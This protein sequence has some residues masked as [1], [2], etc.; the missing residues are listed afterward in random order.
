M[1][2]LKTTDQLHDDVLQLELNIQQNI[3]AFLA[4]R[5]NV[6]RFDLSNQS[7]LFGF[8]VMY[9]QSLQ[10]NEDGEIIVQFSPHAQRPKPMD[11]CLEEGL[12]TL[13]QALAIIQHLNEIQ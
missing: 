13:R 1:K 11:E 3:A 5:E 4:Q 9:I 10:L 6:Y 2:E 7:I 12:I 8:L